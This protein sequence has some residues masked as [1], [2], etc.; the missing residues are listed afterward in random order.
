MHLVVSNYGIVSC[1]Y[2][3][4]TQYLYTLF[5]IV[6]DDTEMGI[7]MGIVYVSNHYCLIDSF[8]VIQVLLTDIYDITD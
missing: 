3:L 1:N 7:N 4:S 8:S 6:I 2:L 5:V